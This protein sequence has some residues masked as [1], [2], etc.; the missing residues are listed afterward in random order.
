MG[1]AMPPSTPSC[2]C[3]Q[4]AGSKASAAELIPRSVCSIAAASEDQAGE[5]GQ[6]QLCPLAP[7]PLS[8]QSWWCQ[9]RL[10]PHAAVGPGPF[11][12]SCASAAGPTLVPTPLMPSLLPPP[13]SG[14]GGKA[15]G[16]TPC[17]PCPLCLCCHGSS[18][19][20]NSLGC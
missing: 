19:P 6:G 7:S 16:P 14:R 12:P 17:P 18:L 4:G 1:G 3:I 13:W 5:G 20:H 2:S 9:G 11:P 8:P 10:F 15:K